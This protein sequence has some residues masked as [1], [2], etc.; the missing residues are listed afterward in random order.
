MTARGIES[1]YGAS[2][3]VGLESEKRLRGHQI[4]REG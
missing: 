1:G 4:V 3:P 2:Q